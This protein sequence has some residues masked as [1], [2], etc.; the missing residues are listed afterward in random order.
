MRTVQIYHIIFFNNSSYYNGNTYD[1]LYDRFFV[2]N[3]MSLY[4]AALESNISTCFDLY[5]TFLKRSSPQ[6]KFTLIINGESDKT[7]LLL[8]QLVILCPKDFSYYN[9]L[10]KLI[11]QDS[12]IFNTP[13]MLY[14]DSSLI[15]TNHDKL[16]DIRD[17]CIDEE[18]RLQILSAL[19]KYISS[20]NSNDFNPNNWMSPNVITHI[21]KILEITE[22]IFNGYVRDLDDVSI[23][24]S[25][26]EYNNQ[27]TPLRLF[28][29]YKQYDGTEHQRSIRLKFNKDG[30][31]IIVHIYQ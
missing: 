6:K 20:V 23:F 1:F 15:Y 30:T 19:E 29:Y 22:P 24:L 26:E 10:Q 12:W 27:Y 8:S 4:Q 28:F 13:D 9:T 16:L 5:T 3:N 11:C 7:D 17:K 25:K 18:L 14:I 31:F 2:L 21:I